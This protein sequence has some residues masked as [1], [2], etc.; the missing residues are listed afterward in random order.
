MGSSWP[1]VSVI[2]AKLFTQA[3][4]LD[5]HEGIDRG[6]KRLGSLED[7][8]SDVVAL[9][10]FAAPSQRLIDEVFQ[11][12]LPAMRLVE[13]AAVKDADQLLSNGLL[14]GFAPAIE[15]NCRQPNRSLVARIALSAHRCPPSGKRHHA[16]S[17]LTH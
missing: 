6:V 9:E 16:P 1:S 3:G 11:E 8:Q 14:V 4:G 2:F 10:P 13:R 7:F 17:K 15:R 12:P 5:P